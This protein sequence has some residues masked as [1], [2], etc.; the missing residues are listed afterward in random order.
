MHDDE[1]RAAYRDPRWQ[2][3]RLEVMQSAGFRC[4]N[5]EDTKSTLNV[6]HRSYVNG[7]KPWEYT[8]IELECLC[9]WCHEKRTRLIR[10]LKVV[11]GDLSQADL[12]Q[13]LGYAHG[14][15]MQDM[16]QHRAEIDSYAMAQG[17]ADSS[18][19]NALGAP[20]VIN[21]MAGTSIN[22]FEFAEVKSK[23][24]ESAQ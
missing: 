1:F 21:F 5:C 19:G 11:A 10:A 24:Q 3:K 13:L 4:E 23:C 16:P 9:E 14:L 22:G 2:Q 6:H 8:P 15:F 18:D 17:L 12:Q 7:R 20:E